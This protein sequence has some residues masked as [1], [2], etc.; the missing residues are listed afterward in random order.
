MKDLWKILLLAG[1]G[2]LRQAGELKKAEDENTT[3]KD[4]AQGVTM[5]FA[6]DLVEALAKGKALPKIPAEYNQLAKNDAGKGLTFDDPK[7]KP[8]V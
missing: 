6:A 5:V 8:P 7:S 3:G 2:L 4:D 1:L